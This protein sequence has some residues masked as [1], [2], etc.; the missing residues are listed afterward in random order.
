MDTYSKLGVCGSQRHDQDI[1]EDV[2]NDHLVLDK[3]FGTNGVT[4]ND[5]CET[6]TSCVK[7]W[8]D[9]WVY[10]SYAGLS[11]QLPC[12]YRWVFGI[13]GPRL[14]RKFNTGRQNDRKD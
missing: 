6:N 7:W 1:L 10:F 3:S 5:V 12:C 9:K 14:A 4:R 8:P 2:V 13:H 11:C